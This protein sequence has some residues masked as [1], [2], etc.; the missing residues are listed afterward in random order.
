MVGIFI[1][2]EQQ[3]YRFF[4]ILQFRN[5]CL[6]PQELYIFRSLVTQVFVYKLSLRL[7]KK[8]F[9]QMKK[10]ILNSALA[11]AFF[12]HV[13]ATNPAVKF[14][15]FPQGVTAEDYV[16]N[17]IIIKVKPEFRTQCEANRIAVQ[18]LSSAFSSLQ[19]K[20]TE[21]LFPRHQQPLQERNT[22]GQSLTDISL[23]Y[24]ITYS[25]QVVIEKAINM[26][27]ATGNFIYAEPN[28]IYKPMY[29][30]NDTLVLQQ[31]HHSRIHS[32]E[33]WDINKGDT[34]VVIGITDT[35]FDTVHI[36]L[37]NKIKYNY[38]DPINGIDDDGDGYIDNYMGWNM[39]FNNTNI[40]SNPIH[41]TFVAG[42]A[43]AET[44]NVT[45]IAGVGFKTKFLPVS[46]S[47][48]S[49]VIVNGEMAI[50]Y[51]AD[52]G[53]TII[54]C[55]WGGGVP[56]QFA[57]DIIDYAT[58]N[59]GC[60]VVAAAGNGNNDI[61][62]YP[63]SYQYVLS[64]A[65]TDTADVRWSS[66]TYGS[67]VDVCA[68][69][70][71]VYS[72]FPTGSPNPYW[73][74]GGTSEATPQVSGAAALVKAQF[75]TLTGLQIG[76]RVRVTCD[77]IDTIPGNAAFAG[78]LG[79]GRINI[80]RALTEAAKSA[81]ALYIDMN[82]GNDNAFA[83]FDTL[84]ISAVF[85]NFLDPLSNLS[86]TLSCNSPYI[87][88]LNPTL[89]IGAMA[90]L[91]SDSNRANP[92]RAIIGGAIPI[93][94]KIVFTLT[95]QGGT[96]SDWQK[97]ETTVN[98]DYINLNVNAIGVTITS[99]GRL[100][101]NDAGSTQGIGFTIN[102]GASLLY[103]GGLVVGVNDSMVSDA[104][105]GSSG[106]TTVIDNDFVPIVHVYPVI[107]SVISD[108]DL[109]ATFNDVNST[110]P[111]NVYITN[112]I[113]AWTA[114]A[115][116]NYI[117]TE[118]IIHNNST[119]NYSALYAGIYMDWD[120][121]GATYADNRAD[122]DSVRRMGY[123]YYKVANNNYVG[124]K[125]LTPGV[126]HYYAFNNDG[127]AG[128]INIYGGGLTKQAKYQCM[129]TLTRDSAGYTGTGADISMLFS[130]GPFSVNAGDSV[131]VA[132]AL[133]GGDS[134]AQ[135][136][137]AA[138]TAQIKYNTS[139]VGILEKNY[140]S[141][142]IAFPN[143]FSNYIYIKVESEKNSVA[144]ITLSDVVGR[145][146]LNNYNKEIA[147]GENIIRINTKEIP[148]GFYVCTVTLSGKNYFLKLIK[149]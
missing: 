102:S 124:I 74:S 43:A 7:N 67:Y 137:T 30:P 37:V 93:N 107:P 73:Y 144:T 15:R 10:I 62:F 64:V 77:N 11:F 36:E 81:R 70:Y 66:S 72:I 95:F 131:K 53:A 60:L 141:T 129:S 21:K 130:S 38:N 29:I 39:A 33:A 139:P 122:L 42:I 143:P 140:N 135:I 26:L 101:Y 136:A 103:T 120:I 106:G 138:D 142:L 84:N 117:V 96:Y 104:T 1:N 48:G 105:T 54:N 3:T 6:V 28:Y 56:S 18:N 92:F 99:K 132:F 113:Y 9:H 147:E 98:V 118:Y 31:Y 123:A 100:G 41:G 112:N 34:N 2:Y 68:P 55:S 45:G 4:N 49:N 145:K 50:Q 127:S 71:A 90:T 23:I 16:P 20:S 148:S 111:I 134:L 40:N 46:C 27:L 85:T 86:V 114:P 110:N 13:F 69:G 109:S 14:F 91:A 51:A 108:A 57:Q 25:S 87:N 80:Y 58:I 65:G 35:G 83:G 44:D 121:T 61:P 128:S 119:T 19:I 22:S 63:A 32:Y 76:E 8:H 12:T 75:P 126:P 59:K 52:H 116:N 82:D 133:V 94:S 115:D 78:Q 79:K 146:L 89:N 88:I 125:L 97:F 149:N 17:T 47:P 24:K 5:N